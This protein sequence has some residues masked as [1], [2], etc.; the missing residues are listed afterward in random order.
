MPT[1]RKRPLP[2]RPAGGGACG[3]VSGWVAGVAGMRQTRGTRRDDRMRHSSGFGGASGANRTRSRWQWP[4]PCAPRPA[5][6]R[7]CPGDQTGRGPVA[8]VPARFITPSRCAPTVSHSAFFPARKPHMRIAIGR[9]APARYQRGSKHKGKALSCGAAAEL[10][11]RYCDSISSSAP[12]DV[13][14]YSR[15]GMHFKR[16]CSSGCGGCRPSGRTS[17]SHIRGRRAARRLDAQS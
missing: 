11:S 4:V 17:S 10:C 16:S 9:H 15:F 6:R 12:L 14:L 3:V 7:A 5:F 2:R 13:C 8:P 1:F